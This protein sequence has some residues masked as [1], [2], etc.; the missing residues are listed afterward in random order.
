MFPRDTK[1]LPGS[2][3]A[4]DFMICLV[5]ELCQLTGLTDDQRSNFRLMKDVATYTRITPNQRH[6]A[7]KKVPF[8]IS[9]I[10][11]SLKTQRKVKKSSRYNVN[12]FGLNMK[13]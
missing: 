7:F 5:P 11:F 10:I 6:A 3:Q 8:S 9:V 4:T 1:R 2:E 12:C 13:D